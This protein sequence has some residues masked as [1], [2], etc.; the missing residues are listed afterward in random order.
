MSYKEGNDKDDSIVSFSNAWTAD[1]DIAD[2]WYLAR[3]LG[4]ALTALGPF[5]IGKQ[6]LEEL[7]DGLDTG[8]G[9]GID[10]GMMGI[11]EDE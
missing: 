11:E 3:A 5:L 9:E 7:H 2:F 4:N 1:R 10:L 8:L 6:T